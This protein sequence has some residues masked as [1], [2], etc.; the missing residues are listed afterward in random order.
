MPSSDYGGN[1]NGLPVSATPSKRSGGGRAGRY[2]HGDLKAALVDGAVELIGERG[3]RDFSLAELSRRLGVTVAAP[4]RHFAD[5]DELLAAVAVRALHAFADALAAKSG[6]GESG[7]GESGQGESGQGSPPE[8]RLAAMTRGYVRFAAEQRAL[9]DVVYTT[10]LDKSRYP[11]LEPAYQRVEEPF[12][13]C[14]ARLCPDDPEDAAALED[15]LEANARGHAALL[16]DGSYG[17]EPDAIDRAAAQAAR[18]ALALIQGF[19]IR[20]HLAG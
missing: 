5:R 20:N 11:E 7:E 1:P 9:F 4:Y 13:S 16:L 3:V 18:A 19:G 14:V 10:G 17:E 2:H 12:S 6:Q 15:A 8:Q